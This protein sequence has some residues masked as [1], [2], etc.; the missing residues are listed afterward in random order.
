MV[1][2]ARPLVKPESPW[3]D[4]GKFFEGF[5]VGMGAKSGEEFV[6]LGEPYFYGNTIPGTYNPV[7]PNGIGVDDVVIG[8]GLPLGYYLLADAKVEAVSSLLGVVTTKL[9]E[10]AGAGI[11]PVTAFA[12]PQPKYQPQTN[13]STSPQ[14]MAV[15]AQHRWTGGGQTLGRPP[16]GYNPFS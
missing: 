3:R 10:A 15:S 5:L 2:F 16:H 4:V 8:A 11:A 6:H 9:L 1:K 14:F 7:T 12:V 13:T